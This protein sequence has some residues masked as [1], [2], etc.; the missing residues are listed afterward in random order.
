M[1]A[2]DHARGQ[3]AAAGRQLAR[4][5]GAGHGG[6]ISAPSRR[7]DRDHCDRRTLRVAHRRARGG[8][9]PRRH[10]KRGR[11]GTDVRAGP[12]TWVSI[13]TRA[14]AIVPHP[15]STGRRVG[16]LVDELPCIHYQMLL[17]G[18]RSR[19]L[20]TRRLV[21]GV[22]RRG[23]RR[24]RRAHR[25]ADGQPRRGRARRRLA[26]RV[27]ASV[28]WNGRATST[29]APPP[30]VHPACLDE[31][32]QQAVIE[33]AMRCDYGNHPAYEGAT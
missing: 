12:A 8:R 13:A 14:G 23:A 19:S 25:R 15:R 1:T 7:P 30:S 26:A 27:E 24:A 3:I 9:G 22:G 16:L 28:C 31:A 4:R 10:A 6:N 32:A 5:A 29:C 11:A 2:I 17:L 21:R 18:G 20:R 33:Q